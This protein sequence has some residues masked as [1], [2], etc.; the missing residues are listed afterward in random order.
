M[1]EE[2]PPRTRPL[3]HWSDGNT[4]ITGKQGPPPEPEPEPAQQETPEPDKK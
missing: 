2:H 3:A 1:S 4:D